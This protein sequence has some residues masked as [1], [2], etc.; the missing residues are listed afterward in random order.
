M[1][2]KKEY[3]ILAALIVG[4]SLYL[5]LHDRDRT[6][7]DLPVLQE[8]PASEITKIEISRP[9]GSALTL[10]R[11][12]DRWVILPEAYAAETGKVSAM[13]ESLG[14]ITLTDLVSET[15]SYERYGL[16]K[17][18]RIG[19][20]AWSGEKLKREFDVGKA[21][22]SFQHTFVRVAGDDRV[23]HARENLKSRFDQTT[24]ALRDKTVLKFDPSEVESIELSDGKKTLSLVR[25]RIQIEAGA[26]EGK[27]A[28]GPQE[29]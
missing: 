11:R 5:I 14:K 4:L 17:D 26:A 25:K 7:Y 9:G 16:G 8:V 6:R 24:D 19:V 22:S 27:E 13:L 23:F 21:A 20:K 28:D 2:L 29:G 1:K 12:E 10:E 15:R 3:I 18:E